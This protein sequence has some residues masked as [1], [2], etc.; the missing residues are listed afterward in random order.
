VVIG[1]VFL[2]IILNILAAILYRSLSLDQSGLA[3][4]V[5]LFYGTEFMLL[6]VGLI[7]VALYGR[8]ESATAMLEIG[9][10]YFRDGQ[11]IR[12]AHQHPHYPEYRPAV[13]GQ[14][15]FA[16]ACEPGNPAAN[17]LCG[18]WQAALSTGIQLQNFLAPWHKALINCLILDAL[19]RYGQRSLGSEARFGWR[20]ILLATHQIK[21]DEIAKQLGDNVFVDALRRTAPQWKLL[22]PQGLHLQIEIR[23]RE[24]IWI[25]RHPWHGEIRLRCRREYRTAAPDHKIARIL[26][27]NLPPKQRE[28]LRVL[29]SQVEA[30]ASSRWVF[31]PFG[32]AFHEWATGLLAFLEEELDW[33]YFEQSLPDRMIMDLL[34]MI[35]DLPEGASLWQKV[36]SIEA[37]LTGLVAAVP[38]DQAKNESH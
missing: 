11:Q 38:A 3:R 27:I 37:Q 14:R 16:D 25:L 35:G 13:L 17:R 9:I 7:I 33:V 22:L 20:Q 26:G 29:I 1:T 32:D 10:P 19:H 28:T 21:L 8:R 6:L 18:E 30:K 12:I 5:V 36:E 24:S 34:W 2:G 31:L 4:A 23:E 15:R